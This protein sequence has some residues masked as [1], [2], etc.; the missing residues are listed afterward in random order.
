MGFKTVAMCITSSTCL[1]LAGSPM[2]KNSGVKIIYDGP[3]VRIT[4][5]RPKQPN[6]LNDNVRQ[7]IAATL[8]ELMERPDI[9]VLVLS[10]SGK[11]SLALQIKDYYSAI[12]GII[13]CQDD[14]VFPKENIP[15]IRNHVNW[16]CP[17]SIDFDYY[18]KVVKEAIIKNEIVLAYEFSSIPVKL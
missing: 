18:E 15:T 16:E 9:R 3:L 17:E 11:S 12:K 5:D 6:A 4:L 1:L 10:G 2:S 13:L 8:N 14:Y 7:D